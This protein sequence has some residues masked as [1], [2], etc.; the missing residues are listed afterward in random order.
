MVEGTEI[1]G[2]SVHSFA[3]TQTKKKTKK[4]TEEDYDSEFSEVLRKDRNSK[5][6]SGIIKEE[7]K[8]NNYNL[9]II[10]YGKQ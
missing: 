6:L 1:D 10:N 4:K 9:I 2:A 5:L 3:P 8:N 7:R